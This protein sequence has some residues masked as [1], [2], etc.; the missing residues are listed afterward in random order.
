MR[1]STY[2]TTTCRISIT[3]RV[4]SVAVI[5]AI[6]AIAALAAPNLS[7]T[8]AG[9]G[10]FTASPVQLCSLFSPQFTNQTSWK[11]PGACI[12][13]I[14]IWAFNNGPDPTDGTPVTVSNIFPAGLSKHIRHR[15][16]WW[17]HRRRRRLELQCR[18]GQCE[19][20]SD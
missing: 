7:V 20:H 16:L 10:T 14:T 3:R 12:D 5:L 2:R 19:L 17:R 18:P 4:L 9:A 13:T 1:T 11:G 6:S 15:Q 8:V